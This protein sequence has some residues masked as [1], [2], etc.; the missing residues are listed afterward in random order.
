MAET[1]SISERVIQRLIEASDLEVEPGDVSPATSL[2]DDL[3]IGSLQALTLI[4]DLEEDFEITVEDDE[5][6]QLRTVG[7][8][9]GLLE[10]KQQ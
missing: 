4:M 5:F 8:V 9:I 7:D 2:R 3:E 10:A 6:E 1:A